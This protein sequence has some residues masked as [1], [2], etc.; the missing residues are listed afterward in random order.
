MEEEGL[1]HPTSNTSWARSIIAGA[2]IPS[3]DHPVRAMPSGELLIS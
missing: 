1:S 3:A 2:G